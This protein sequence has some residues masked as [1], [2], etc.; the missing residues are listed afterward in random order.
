M[1]SDFQD[2]NVVI[3]CYRLARARGKFLMEMK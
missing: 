2:F 3:V 1:V